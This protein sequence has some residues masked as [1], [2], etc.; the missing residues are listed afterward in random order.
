M[1]DPWLDRSV[2]ALLGLAVGDALGAPFEGL[3]RDTYPRVADYASGGMHNVEPGAWTDD[4]AMAICLAESLLARDGVDEQDLLERFLR[5][6]RAGEN[7]A[8]GTA[9]GISEKTSATLEAFERSH[10]IDVAV[11]VENPGNGAIMRLAPVAI[12][13]RGSS[14]EARCAAVRQARVTHTASA[15]LEAAGSLAEL[16]VVA[17]RTGDLDAVLQTAASGGHPDLRS[18]SEFRAKTRAQISSVPRAVDTLEAA[19]WCLHHARD[20]EGTVVEAVNLGGDSD[21]IGAVAG[22]LA[23]AI[24]GASVIPARWMASLISRERLVELARQLYQQGSDKF[25]S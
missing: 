25:V 19:L 15:A 18:I 12:L 13:F 22:Q 3:D 20:F 11:A 4:T 21:T 8:T 6:Y 1:P 14:T 16:L 24:F 9:I 5:W 23:G 2:G 17:L 7:S 10:R